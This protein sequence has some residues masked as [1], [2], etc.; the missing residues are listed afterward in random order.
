MTQKT[1]LIVEDDPDL[2]PLLDFIFSQ[3]GYETVLFDRGDT[4]WE[5]LED[6]GLPD[7]IVLDLLV[8]GLDGMAFLKR[9][10]DAEWLQ[11]VPVVVLTGVESEEVIG[12]AFDRGADDYLCK[13]FSQTE[14]L[15]R[16]KHAMG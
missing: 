5:H 10:R 13:P 6:G 12:T 2:S 8:P 11:S 16:V 15:T 7:C 14:L 9:Y 3:N 4:A 1:V